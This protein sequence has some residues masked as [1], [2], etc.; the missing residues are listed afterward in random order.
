MFVRVQLQDFILEISVWISFRG[1]FF[2]CS[3]KKVS[4]RPGQ[5]LLK[6]NGKSEHVKK[7]CVPTDNSIFLFIYF[8][9]VEAIFGSSFNDSIWR[10]EGVFQGNAGSRCS[11]DNHMNTK[12]RGDC[13]RN[14]EHLRRVFL[15]VFS[16]ETRQ[17]VT[18]SYE[19]LRAV[20]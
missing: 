18:V 3:K 15:L 13:G 9:W 20:K 1:S 17:A 2:L 7:W 12:K 19:K 11:R 4:Q 14:A 16:V 10:G 6:A 5:Q 8:I